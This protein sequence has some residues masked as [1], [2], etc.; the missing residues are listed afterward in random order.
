M[1][2]IREIIGSANV[3][4]QERFTAKLQPHPSL[5]RHISLYLTR[6]MRIFGVIDSDETIGFSVGDKSS[7]IEETI[8]P[9]VSAMA[10]FREQVR[11]EAR[12]LKATNI[13][14]YCD[15]V[16]DDVLPNLG[17]RLEDREGAAPAVKLVDRDTLMKEREQKL[18]IEEEKRIEKERKKMEAE[19]ARLAKEKLLRT[20]AS[21]LFRSQI[22]KFSLFDEKG[23][24]TH[25]TEGK[26]LSKGLLKK[27]QKQYEDHEKKF[28]ELSKN[29][30]ALANGDAN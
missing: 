4:I 6:M 24:P 30:S 7:N 2:V 19:E 5:L 8:L 22:D 11:Q 26:E 10:D 29:G 28:K 13:L 16:R 1:D 18:K 17:V 27:L 14:K 12:T 9:Y 21:E 15:I 23:L 25:D 20:P 3:Y